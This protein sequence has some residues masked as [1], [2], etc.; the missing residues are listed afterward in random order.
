MLMRVVASG[1]SLGRHEWRD[2]MRVARGTLGP[3]GGDYDVQ[4]H[5]G[6]RMSICL[7]VYSHPS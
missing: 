2:P 4:H 3:R 1:H 6:T 5:L 7:Y